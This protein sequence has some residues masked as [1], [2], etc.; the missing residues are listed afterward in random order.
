MRLTPLLFTLFFTVLSNAAAN[1][2]KRGSKLAT[3]SKLSMMPMDSNAIHQNLTGL[4]LEVVKLSQKPTKSQYG[5]VMKDGIVCAEKPGTM[6][7]SKQS[8]DFFG[9]MKLSSTDASSKIEGGPVGECS[10]VVFFFLIAIPY[11]GH[12]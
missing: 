3:L 10:I 4:A 6:A 9:V 1:N 7:K 5:N 12:C 2:G 8:S 11:D